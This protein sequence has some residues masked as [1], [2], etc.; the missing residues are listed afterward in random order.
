MIEIADFTKG[1]NYVK[2]LP[3][4]LLIA[5]FHGNEVV[6]TNAFYYFLKSFNKHYLK[7]NYYNNLV[8]NVRI[9]ILP[10]ANVNGFA[11]LHREEYIN[12]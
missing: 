12:G 3:T 6:G 8:K 1:E 10:T 2:K 4:I 7:N 5:G 11:N 9:L